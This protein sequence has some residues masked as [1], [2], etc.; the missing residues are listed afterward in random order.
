[1][2]KAQAVAHL[3]SRIGPREEI[4]VE[5]E[6]MEDYINSALQRTTE[7]LATSVHASDFQREDA[8]VLDGAGAAAVPAD[9]LPGYII[10]ISHASDPND[11][12]ILENKGEFNFVSC[13]E[14]SYA[15]IETRKIY[16]KP[17]DGVDAP[18]TGN[19]N[20]EGIFIPAIGALDDKYEDIFLNHL[21]EIAAERLKLNPIGRDKRYAPAPQPV[22]T[23]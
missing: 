18:L 20:V 23:R 6:D 15:S 5:S 14:F 1:M 4:N 16:T 3:E 19:L 2:N 11:F 17:K 7:D 8:I 13:T 21:T 9:F 22:V 12:I 10:R